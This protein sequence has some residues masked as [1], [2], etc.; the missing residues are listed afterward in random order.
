MDWNT[1]GL[2]VLYH[3]PEFAETHVHLVSNAIQP[4]HPPLPPSP[5]IL[6][7]FQ[8]QGLFQ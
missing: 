2:P 7:L 3:L 5:P 8:Y 4:S 1:A 6:N